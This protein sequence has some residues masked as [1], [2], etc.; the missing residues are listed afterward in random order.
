MGHYIGPKARINRR[1]GIEVYDSSGSLRAS[2]RRIFPP[3]QHS[4]RRRR[5][6][7]YGRALLEKQKICHYYGLSQRQL[8]RFFDLAKKAP[9]NTGDNLL[10]LCERR[11]DSIVWKAGFT[12]TRQQARQAVAHGH[13]TVNGRKTDIPSYI[14]GPEDV[15]QVRKR[16]NLAKLYS[17]LV[18]DVDRPQA[19]FLAVEKKDLLIKVIRNPDKD[20]VGL[21][22]NVN[23]VVELLS[24]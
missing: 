2:H 16:E 10:T 14:L 18:E 4:Q 24:R 7:D 23:Q 1:L 3:G 21:P 17:S 5:P 13:V 22:V 9:G 12:R 8:K 20:D 11:L 19:S 15:V 6:S